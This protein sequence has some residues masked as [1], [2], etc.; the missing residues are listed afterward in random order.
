MAP[1]TTGDWETVNFRPTCPRLSNGTV[2]L[3]VRLGRWTVVCS[4]EEG[5]GRPRLLSVGRPICLLATVPSPGGPVDGDRRGPLG[6]RCREPGTPVPLRRYRQQ[7]V[8]W[9]SKVRCKVDSSS[10]SPSSVPCPRHR[11]PCGRTVCGVDPWTV[12]DHRVSGLL[13]VWDDWSSSGS[14]PRTTTGRSTVR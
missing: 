11:V 2:P 9:S 10:L 8:Y 6:K 12:R 1:G 13:G 14:G 5:H 4:R 7:K 3:C